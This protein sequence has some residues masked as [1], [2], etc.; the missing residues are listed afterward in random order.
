MGNKQCKSNDTSN[1]QYWIGPYG[2]LVPSKINSVLA[3]DGYNTLYSD[4]CETEMFRIDGPHMDATKY[5]K[6]YATYNSNNGVW[7]Y[8]KKY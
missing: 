5:K 8:T 2:I 7:Y 6:L 3:E 1:E 4:G